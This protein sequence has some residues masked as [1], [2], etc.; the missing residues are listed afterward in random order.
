[1]KIKS[2]NKLINYYFK[3]EAVKLLQFL[4]TDTLRKLLLMAFVESA[5]V[6]I[7]FPL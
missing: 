2:I 1:M 7:F 6:H 4:K 3:L 5:S